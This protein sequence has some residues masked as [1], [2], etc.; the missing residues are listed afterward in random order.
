MKKY[1]KLFN[2]HSEYESFMQTGD[3]IK[4]NDL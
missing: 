1:I 2:T 4:P 3:F